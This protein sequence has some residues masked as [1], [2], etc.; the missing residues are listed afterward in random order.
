MGTHTWYNMVDNTHNI[1]AQHVIYVYKLTKMSF[2]C[3]QIPYFI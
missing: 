2:G 1:G 3:T